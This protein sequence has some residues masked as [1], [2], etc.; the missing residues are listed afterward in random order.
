MLARAPVL[1]ADRRFTA[2]IFGDGGFAV[3][4]RP[5][6]WPAAGEP[7]GPAAP[8]FQ[9]SVLGYGPAGPG[10]AAELAS[11]V[12][13]WAVAGRPGAARFG[14]SAYPRATGEPVPP[15]GAVIERPHTTFVVR[16]V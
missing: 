12:E 3:L 9:L 11:T 14:I 13:A 16:P 7:S 6:P 4:A 1:L 5:A 8:A 15:V 10:L 2:G